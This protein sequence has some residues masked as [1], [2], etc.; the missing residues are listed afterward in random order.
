MFGNYQIAMIIIGSL[1]TAVWL[2][3]QNRETFKSMPLWK[4]F[5]GE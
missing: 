2:F 1:A 4:L 5:G 3:W